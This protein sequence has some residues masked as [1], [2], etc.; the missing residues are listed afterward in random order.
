MSSI[1]FDTNIW[2][3]YK[4]FYRSGLLLSA[5]VLQ[6]LVIGAADNTEVKRWE[7][8]RKKYGKEDKLLVQTAEDWWQAGKIINSLLRGLKSESHGETPRLHPNQKHRIIRDALIAVTAHRVG[9]LV[10]TDNLAD[11]E[12]I[13]RYCKVKIDTPLPKER[14]FLDR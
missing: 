5:V 8:M 9:A 7:A 6:E 3:S 1:V 4:P 2:I 14:G 12:N 10:V 13:R 11:F